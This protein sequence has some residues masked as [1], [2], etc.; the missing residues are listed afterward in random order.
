MSDPVPKCHFSV[1]PEVIVFIASLLDRAFLL[2]YQ[3]F[4]FDAQCMQRVQD[5]PRY[6]EMTN[7]S[8]E[9]ICQVAVKSG[10]GNSYGPEIRRLERDVSAET[11]RWVFYVALCRFVPGFFADSILGPIGDHFSRKLALMLP[12]TG[13]LLMCWIVFIVANYFYQYYYLVLLGVLVYGITGQYHGIVAGVLAYAAHHS[14]IDAALETAP[15]I[16]EQEKKEEVA[17][18]RRTESEA[19]GDLPPPETQEQR[20]SLISS[21]RISILQ[22]LINF[23]IGVGLL[24]GGLFVHWFGPALAFGY[25]AVLATIAF[26][27]VLFGIKDLPAAEEDSYDD[28]VKAYGKL[29]LLRMP[30]VFMADAYFATF[31]KPRPAS[32]RTILGLVVLALL[33]FVFCYEL[34]PFIDWL[35]LSLSPRSFTPLLYGIFSLI[36]YTLVGIVLVTI[37]PAVYYIFRDKHYFPV[38]VIIAVFGMVMLACAYITLALAQNKFQVFLSLPFD[39][40]SGLPYSAMRIIIANLVPTHD[41]GIYHDLALYCAI[42]M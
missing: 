5:D 26:F 36:K 38:N 35:Y 39:A 29:W 24:S 33:A 9:Y 30:A 20:M 25:L 22:A 14:A 16:K 8:A 11:S 6:M 32:E 37:L 12:T 1:P 41:C 34:H 4:I 42:C 28:E 23:G 3:P 27:I 2:I 7:R 17:A 18:R 40:W 21:T 19:A 31:C 13:L 10:N 15:L